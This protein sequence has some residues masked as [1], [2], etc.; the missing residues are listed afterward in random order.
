MHDC[1]SE[2]ASTDS[3]HHLISPDGTQQQQKNRQRKLNGSLT[4]KERA[5]LLFY[6]VSL[7]YI[8]F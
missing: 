8:L 7:L 4:S 3:T 5:S 6:L 2:A 1:A